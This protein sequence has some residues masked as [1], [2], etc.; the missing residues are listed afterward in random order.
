[1]ELALNDEYVWNSAQVTYNVFWKL[2]HS[3][4]HIR[5]LVHSSHKGSD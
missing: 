2:V 5:L 4:E 1:M 3:E